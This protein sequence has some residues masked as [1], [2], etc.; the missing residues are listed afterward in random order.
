MAKKINPMVA[1]AG[2]VVAVLLLFAIISIVFYPGPDVVVDDHHSAEDGHGVEQDHSDDHVDHGAE[3]DHG[4]EEDGS[5]DVNDS[6]T[7][8]DDHTSSTDDTVSSNDSITA[9][10]GDTVSAHYVGKFENGTVFA[11]TNR[12]TGAQPI[13]FILGK[14]VIVKGFDDAV[15]GMKKGETKTVVVQPKDGFPSNPDLII[16]FSRAQIEGVFG[17]VPAVGNEITFSNG[18]QIS[19]GVVQE[20]T[21]TTVIIDFNSNTVGKVL[22]YEI[23]VVDI[24]RK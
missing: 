17:S 7:K 21:S 22:T 6:D 11:S 13:E 12:E 24:S 20:V 14:G 9:A 10:I 15:L 2:G 16:T 1:I 8:D 4:A 19:K 18:N 3:G 5:D 23:T